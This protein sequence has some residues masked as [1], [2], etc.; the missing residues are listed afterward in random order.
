M[1]A[2]PPG[3]NADL[4]VEP[5]DLLR[6]LRCVFT[7]HQQVLGTLKPFTDIPRNDEPGVFTTTNRPLVSEME[8]RDALTQ[9]IPPGSEFILCLTPKLR[10]RM[11][12]TLERLGIEALP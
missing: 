2:H 9:P 8:V 6:I 10:D 3:S 11:S 12:D 5:K 7:A 1:A 4:D